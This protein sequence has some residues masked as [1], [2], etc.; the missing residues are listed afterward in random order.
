MQGNSEGALDGLDVF[1]LLGMVV[2]ADAG[3]DNVGAVLSRAQS[4]GAGGDRTAILQL[5]PRTNRQSLLTFSSERW[6][7]GGVGIHR[8]I[9]SNSKASMMVMMPWDRRSDLPFSTCHVESPSPFFFFLF[10]WIIIIDPIS[11]IWVIQRL[12]FGTILDAPSGIVDFACGRLRVGG[13]Q[14]R[15][16]SYFWWRRSDEEVR[17]ED[18]AQVGRHRKFF[19]WCIV[20]IVIVADLKHGRTDSTVR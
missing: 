19:F 2:T 9:N 15:R 17:R 10:F 11:A 16:E 18:A 1:F 14:H 4:M 13:F 3:V 7:R 12:A 6:P 5:L 20:V 8:N